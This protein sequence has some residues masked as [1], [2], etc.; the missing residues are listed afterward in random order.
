MTLT[1][2][3]T[4]TLSLTRHE[5]QLGGPDFLECEAMGDRVRVRVKVRLG[6]GLGLGVFEC[7]AMGGI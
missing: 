6:L 1:L 2:T 7:K 3:L 4:L 5:L